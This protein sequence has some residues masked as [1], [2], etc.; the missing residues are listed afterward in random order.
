M[1][2]FGFESEYDSRYLR[3][4]PYLYSKSIFELSPNVSIL[5]INKFENETLLDKVKKRNVFAR[6]SWEN[7][8]YVERL[9]HFCEK[10][11]ISIVK[12]GTPQD[13]Q[14]LACELSEYVEHILIVATIFS[15]DRESLQRKYFSTIS[16]DYDFAYSQDMKFLKSRTLSKKREQ[17]FIDDS[18]IKRFEKL[19]FKNVFDY[20][21]EPNELAERIKKSV[22]W[23]YESRVEKN[24]NAAIVKT[25]IA[26]ESLLIF[27]DSESLS[28]SLSERTAFL[29]TNEPKVRSIISKI[30]IE[31]YNA[32]SGIVHGGKKR[33][34]S[35]NRNVIESM[36]RLIALMIILICSNKQIWNT[37]ESLRLWCENQ[38][39]GMSYEN[40]NTCFSK[41]YLS[42]AIKHSKIDL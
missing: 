12:S 11:V 38:R 17:I 29:L 9:S 41:N 20:F 1:G 35:I 42:N 25:S 14:A 32:R 3:V 18:F 16:S 26:L 30:V 21:N 15:L 31:F 24:L 4:I 28:K 7:N 8:F 33:I 23:L 39:W 10:T 37:N 22:N 34:K 36:D 40:I 13:I 6:H 27:S 2:L 19:G 5:F